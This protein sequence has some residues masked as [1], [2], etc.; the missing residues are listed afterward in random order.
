MRA[1]G[2]SGRNGPGQAAQLGQTGQVARRRGLQLLA[3]SCLP[4]NDRAYFLHP[5]DA[6][7]AQ[8]AWAWVASTH[9]FWLLGQLL[10][11]CP[12]HHIQ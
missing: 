1:A 3:A 12:N 6:C 11:A 5:P 2:T 4:E 7:M 8:T 10:D 9:L